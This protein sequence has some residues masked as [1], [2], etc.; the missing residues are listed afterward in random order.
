[1]KT[2]SRGR[3]Q[4]H[5]K[6]RKGRHLTRGKKDNRKSWCTTERPTGNTSAGGA[7]I[8]TGRAEDTPKQGLK[9]NHIG[10]KDR[11]GGREKRKRRRSKTAR[12]EREGGKECRW[13]SLT[14]ETKSQ[15]EERE[16]EEMKNEILFP[17]SDRPFREWLKDKLITEE[18]QRRHERLWTYYEGNHSG[19]RQRTRT[20]KLDRKGRGTARAGKQAICCVKR[21]RYLCMKRTRRHICANDFT[22]DEEVDLRKGDVLQTLGRGDEQEEWYVGVITRITTHRPLR[23]EIRY[24]DGIKTELNMRIEPWV[25]HGNVDTMNMTIDEWIQNCKKTKVVG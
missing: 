20:G 16:K 8:R 3:E 21:E 25:L 1:M 24:E 11:K 7:G 15:K 4:P 19:R 13:V 12:A 22:T 17:E 2:R 18:H 9:I 14:G 6:P 10:S 5:R 23:A